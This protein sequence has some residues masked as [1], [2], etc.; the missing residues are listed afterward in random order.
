MFFYFILT[1]GDAT[2]KELEKREVESA[3]GA[4]AL[5]LSP[6]ELST[7]RREKKKVATVTQCRMSYTHCRELAHC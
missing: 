2:K 5:V 7:P 1:I 3:K 4:H 6:H